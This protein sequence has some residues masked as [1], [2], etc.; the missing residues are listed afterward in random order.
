METFK[1]ILLILMFVAFITFLLTF[2]GCKTV[3]KVEYVNNYDTVYLSK[4]EKDSVYLKDS[5][6]IYSK[7]DTVYYIKWKEK[8][9]YLVKTDTIFKASNDTLIVNKE[10]IK[11]VEKK[12]RTRDIL[13][14]LSTTSAHE[15][16]FADSAWYLASN[17][18]QCQSYISTARTNGWTFVP[19]YNI[20][21]YDDCKTQSKFNT[22]SDGYYLVGT[23]ASTDT[24]PC[25][26][27]LGQVYAMCNEPSSASSGQHG[28]L[29]Y[30]FGSGIDFTNITTLDIK[31][32]V[33]NY[34]N[35]SS[36]TCLVRN[37]YNTRSATTTQITTYNNNLILYVQLVD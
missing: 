3:E 5:V 19:T 18:F 22:A 16:R 2:N 36:T 20:Y 27:E 29:E 33:F 34:T 14:H 6:Y 1:R 10:I 15:C 30:R 9:K 8:I 17:D 23:E 31:A 28:H 4:V 35:T 32:K 7:A 25:D 13:S 24:Y 11:E 37:G 21:Y 26:I 12:R